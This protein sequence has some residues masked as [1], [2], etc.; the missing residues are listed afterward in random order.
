M[1]KFRINVDE[2]LKGVVKFF[3]LKNLSDLVFILVLIK[4][5]FKVILNVFKIK[6]FMLVGISVL[7]SVVVFLLL[8]V[9]WYCYK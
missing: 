6:F 8:F 9:L 4:I 2:G 1:D 5:M 7:W 3:M